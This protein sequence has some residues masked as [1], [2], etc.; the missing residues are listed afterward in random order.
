MGLS[1]VTRMNKY[2]YYLFDKKE[3]V[4][5]EAEDILEADK[6]LQEQTGIVALNNPR[7]LVDI[8]FDKSIDQV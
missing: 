3:T 2:K 5:I 4:A 8:S 1:N 7:V 6:K